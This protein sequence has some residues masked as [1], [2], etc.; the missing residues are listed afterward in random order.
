MIILA[1]ESSG[2]TAGAALL[3][4]ER[5]L[6]EFSTANKKTHSQ[7]LLPMIDLITE[8]AGICKKD[9]GAV[10][11]SVGPGS[12]TGLRIGVATAKGI[13]MALGIP[14]V[15]VSTLEGLAYNLKGHG[16]LICPMIDA[17]RNEVFC[18]LYRFVKEELETV[19]KPCSMPAG[20][21]FALL[22][23][24]G[25][26]VTFLGDG[27]DVQKVHISEEVRVPFAF[28]GVQHNLQRAASVGA[29]GLKYLKEGRGEA[30]EELSPVYLKM[31]QA[32]RERM[33]RLRRK[34]D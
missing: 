12:F 34:N 6:A 3:D 23:E 7:T 9:I 31:T 26:Q 27:A 33:E 32:E 13:G 15:G 10:A 18:G 16:G 25:E 4:E 17:R 11:V 8:R 24:R 30:A 20:E 22:N 19:L 2:I 5:V 14:L 21:L 28:A 1:I 29:L